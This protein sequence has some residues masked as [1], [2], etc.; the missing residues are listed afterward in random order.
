MTSAEDR[1]FPPIPP[2]AALMMA[3]AVVAVH[4]RGGTLVDV[5]AALADLP[6]QVRAYCLPFKV[7]MRAALC[8]TAEDYRRLREDVANQARAYL[9][10]RR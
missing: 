5:D 4:M 6:L 1:I 9:E 3:R 10:S 7:G 8:D 2:R